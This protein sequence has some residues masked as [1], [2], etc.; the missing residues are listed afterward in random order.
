VQDVLAAHQRAIE[1]RLDEGLQRIRDAVTEATRT[2]AA[3]TVSE[4][5]RAPPD[6][7]DV[8]RALLTHAEERFQALG[9][10]LQHIEESLRALATGPQS[11]PAGEIARLEKLVRELGRHQGEA[12]A[13]LAGAHRAAIVRLAQD[14]RTALDELGRRTGQGVV[15]VARAVQRDLEAGLE[16]VR[17]SIRSMHRTL[18]WDGMARSRPDP[19]PGEDE[20]A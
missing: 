16:D 18:A 15:A 6:P 5:K 13:R 7:S 9:L 19:R 8:S 3:E 2:A 17:T 12:M 1:E 10:R 14:Q 4:G 11:D 20:S